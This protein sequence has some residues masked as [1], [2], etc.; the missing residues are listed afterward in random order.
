M[1]HDPAQGMHILSFSEASASF[2]GVTLELRPTSQFQRR[3]APPSV[4]LRHM[5]GQVSGLYRSLAQILLLAFALEVF[6]LL[7]PFLLQW[8]IDPVIVGADWD[9]LTT[10]V[11][12][13]FLLLLMQQA[14]NAIRA[15]ALMHIGSTLH[16][17]W[18]ANVFA[19][20]GTAGAIL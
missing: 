1:I 6:A 5:M 3:A 15:W 13:F 20:A 4:K 19:S 8:I 10:L 11:L 14:V 12:E 2:T 18:Y 7:S 17:Q 9:L 16:V